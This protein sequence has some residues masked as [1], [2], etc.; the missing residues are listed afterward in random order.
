MQLMNI[1]HA[2]K[3]PKVSKTF[4][5]CSDSQLKDGI[6]QSKISEAK[7]SSAWGAMFGEYGVG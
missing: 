1:K 3:T 6:S 5:V 7:S 2:E 4:G